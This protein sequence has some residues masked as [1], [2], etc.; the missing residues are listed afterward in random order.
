LSTSLKGTKV[1]ESLAHAA[2]HQLAML[3]DLVKT[4]MKASLKWP[5]RLIIALLITCGVLLAS[6]GV[7][8]YLLVHENSIARQANNTAIQ[9]KAL[10]KAVQDG[11]IR[12]CQNSNSY[13]AD[14]TKI[15]DYIFTLSYAQQAP[16]KKS[17][18]Y[19]VQQEFLR[20]VNKTDAPKD[21]NAIYG[22]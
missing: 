22:K 2:E 19:Q 21:C 6:T 14:Q 12:D 18:T 3:D 15:W 17:R 1:P 20:F 5:K 9:Q 4:A 13:R 11:A 7:T 16:D 8:S 10:V